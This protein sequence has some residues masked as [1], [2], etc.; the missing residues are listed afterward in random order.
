MQRAKL[1]QENTPEPPQAKAGAAPA[2]APPGVNPATKATEDDLDKLKEELADK[3]TYIKELEQQVEENNKE[4][5][6]VSPAAAPAAATPAATI[7]NLIA[8]YKAQ[9]A[10]SDRRIEELLSILTDQ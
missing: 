4:L 7:D 8:Q 2:A 3:D 9:I 5:Q 10:Q 1:A 6:K